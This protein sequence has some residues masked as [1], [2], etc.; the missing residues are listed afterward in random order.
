MKKKYVLCA[1][2]TFD[3][4]AGN[5]EM[6]GGTPV[7]QT[8][9]GQELI[10][11]RLG[12]IHLL[13]TNRITKD[14]TI[15]TLPERKFLYENIFNNVEDYIPGKFD[16]DV[17]IISEFDSETKLPYK[18]FYQH[19]ERDKEL[20]QNIPY[21]EDILSEELGDFL[22]CIPRLKKS[23]LARNLDQQYW[24]DFVSL[25][26]DKFDKIIVFGKGNENFA[27]GDKVR[28]VDTLRDYC[29]YLHHKACKHVVSTVSGPCQYVQFF[30]NTS[31]DAVLTMID[32][33]GFYA[34]HGDSPIYFH[35]CL[36]FSKVKIRFITNKLP[37]PNQLQK[38]I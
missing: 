5:G 18:P 3:V 15:V 1:R 30:G 12:A 13:Q 19:Y 23:E 35:P 11:N 16:Y 20:I 6:F 36:N 37:T 28:Y 25:V 4:N 38:Q 32:N 22:V 9:A 24:L 2:G 26:K 14:H 31:G 17:D 7:N 10:I 34:R 21:N 27:D 33:H 29:S 8:E